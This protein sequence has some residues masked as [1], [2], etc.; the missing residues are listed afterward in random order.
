MNEDAGDDGARTLTGFWTG[1]YAY[2]IASLAP[3]PFNM[4]LTETGGAL[5]GECVEPDSTGSGL[6]ELFASIEGVRDGADVT[7]AKVYESS[8]ALSHHL[9]YRGQANTALT[10]IEG[11][12]TAIA[13]DGRRDWSGVFTMT[14]RSG[15]AAVAR[16][17]PRRARA[18][19]SAD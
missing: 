16:L 7:F 9:D 13:G 12:W 18:P 15:Q 14:R 3:V 1:V 4:V 11:A 2:P 6:G 5:Q 10:R 19:I 17:A 8:I